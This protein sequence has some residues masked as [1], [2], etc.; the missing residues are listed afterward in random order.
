MYFWIYI[1]VK[2]AFTRSNNI[3]HYL[4]LKEDMRS[5]G[6]GNIIVEF[7]SCEIAFRVCQIFV[8]RKSR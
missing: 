8:K 5:T 1:F 6:T 4:E 3:D 7:F 2:E